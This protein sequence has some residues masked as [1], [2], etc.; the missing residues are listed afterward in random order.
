[1]V[2]LQDGIKHQIVS[3]GVVRK[4]MAYLLF[5]GLPSKGLRFISIDE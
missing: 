4:L 5:E 1:M 3:L 2:T